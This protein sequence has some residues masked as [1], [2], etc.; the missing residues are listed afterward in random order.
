MRLMWRPTSITLL[1]ILSALGVGALCLLGGCDRPD[2]KSEGTAQV[3]S[4]APTVEAPP[5]EPPGPFV[6]G[7]WSGTTQLAPGEWGGVKAIPLEPEALEREEWTPDPSRPDET[8]PP[9]PD[10]G[11]SSFA[12]ELSISRL[13]ELSGSAVLQ[14]PVRGLRA[15]AVARGVAELPEGPVRVELSGDQ[16]HGVL[17]LER[18]TEQLA[19]RV[20]MSL[21]R[22]D[23][24]SAVSLYEGIMQLS[25]GERP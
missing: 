24:K 13:G 4:P 11:K 3:A 20:R 10:A 25:T 12:L 7:K 5:P 23:E 14:D 21:V 1:P 16:A 17:V 6:A 22:G 19:G 8:A 9:P 15:E 2:K 18:Q